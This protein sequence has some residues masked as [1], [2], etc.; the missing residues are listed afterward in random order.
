MT[1][2][3]S[4]NFLYLVW[5]SLCSNLFFELQRDNE[6]LKIANFGPKALLVMLEFYDKERGLL[7]MFFAS[8]QN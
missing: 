2:R 7:N 1:P 3:L 5:F 6:V 4:V 8:F